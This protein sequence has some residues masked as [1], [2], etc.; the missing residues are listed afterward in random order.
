MQIPLSAA[1]KQ[2]RQPPPPLSQ[3]L[4]HARLF[5][6]ILLPHRRGFESWNIDLLD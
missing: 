5:S 4:K 1:R 2:T 6:D 3:T